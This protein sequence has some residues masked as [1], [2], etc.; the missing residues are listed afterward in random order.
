VSS[1][2]N[3]NNVVQN[4]SLAIDI[5]VTVI[6][7]LIVFGAAKKL[8]V[9]GFMGA[10]KVKEWTRSI[11]GKTV[12]SLEAGLETIAFIFILFPV[13]YIMTYLTNPNITTQDSISLYQIVFVTDLPIVVIIIV[14]VYLI[15]IFNVLIRRKRSTK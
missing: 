7:A 14:V 8:Q 3:I 15:L 10:S 11:Y 12:S 9:A 5:L 4:W 13:I 2:F 1:I 6:L